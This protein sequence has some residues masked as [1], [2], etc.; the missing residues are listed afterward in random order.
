MTPEELQGLLPSQEVLR[1]WQTVADAR[2]WAGLSEAVLG[3]FLALLGNR[4]LSNLPLQA[5]IDPIMVRR[6]IGDVRV[7]VDPTVPLEGEEAPAPRRLT[8]IEKTQLCL[9]YN[10]VRVKFGLPPVDVVSE[11]EQTPTGVNQTPMDK[12]EVAPTLPLN[13]L[14]KIRLSS[15]LDQVSDAEVQMLPP[16]VIAEKRN[17]YRMITGGDPL[18]QCNFTDAQ[19]SALSQRVAGGQP[20]Y[21]DFA[22]WGPY[23]SRI[24]K[25]MKFRSSFLDT[26]GNWKS[27]EVPGP[28]SFQVWEECWEVFAAAC[29]ADGIATQATLAMYAA[30]FKSRVRDF[31]S[32]CWQICVE[33]DVI[34]RSEQFVL[35]HARQF[36]IFRANPSASNFDPKRP[37]ESVMRAVALDR[38]FWDR[39]LEKPALR[40]ELQGGPRVPAFQTEA[41]TESPKKR[42]APPS[43]PNPPA[44]KAK[45]GKGGNPQD[46]R[47]KDGRYYRGRNGIELCF[48]WGREDGACS[49]PCPH[50]RM[51]ACEWCR[52]PHRS[53]RCPQHPNWKPEKGP[54]K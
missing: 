17:N 52:Q 44:K 23:G 47:R 7:P 2:A 35:E 53:I 9:F 29:I 5:A 30:E 49:E 18:E 54:S 32:G 11:P 39:Q 14:H 34:A 19:L 50:A 20:P 31:G 41:E 4:E 42:P 6:T 43:K 38:A 25:R 1:G 16:E 24:E 21:A 22:V 37:W 12:A 46:Q 27:I 8:T 33:A 13:P 10:A 26:S 28:S 48:K 45:G 36:A 51:H 40:R 15:V 3:E